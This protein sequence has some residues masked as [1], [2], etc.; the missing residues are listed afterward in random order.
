MA[1]VSEMASDL[2][3]ESTTERTAELI[4]EYACQDTACGD[5]E[6][7]LVQAQNVETAVATS[8]RVRKVDECRVRDNEGPCVDALRGPEYFIVDD[9]SVDERWRSRLTRAN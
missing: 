8:S 2:Q 5:A 7:M 3:A 9:T 1:F 4:T 6:I